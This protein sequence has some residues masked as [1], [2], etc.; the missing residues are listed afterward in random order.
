MTQ[1]HKI[2]TQNVHDS[3]SY[4]AESGLDSSSHAL[5]Y[6]LCL[7]LCLIGS[8]N[9]VSDICIQHLLQLRHQIQGQ[10]VLY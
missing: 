9:R 5:S 3:Q 8:Q 2:K 1:F 7:F 6:A 10:Y 4:K